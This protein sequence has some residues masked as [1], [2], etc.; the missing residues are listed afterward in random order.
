MLRTMHRGFKRHVDIL[1]PYL[2]KQ[3]NWWALKYWAVSA[4]SEAD[5]LRPIW[6]RCWWRALRARKIGIAGWVAG[7][8]ADEG[9]SDI[10]IWIGCFTTDAEKKGPQYSYEQVAI[11]RD[12]AKNT[13][14]DQEKT[15]VIM[16]TWPSIK[17]TIIIITGPH[18]PFKIT[19]N[20]STGRTLT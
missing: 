17:S 10:T 16:Q 4:A 7:W 9:Q 15:K 2:I 6:L 5:I 13:D 20:S 19:F 8:D 3:A 1:P 18:R 11:E 12:Y 14:I